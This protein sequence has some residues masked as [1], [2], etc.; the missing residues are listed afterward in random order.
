MALEEILQNTDREDNLDFEEVKI[1]TLIHL[2][3]QNTGG[4]LAK[5][6]REPYKA[7]FYKIQKEM[8][9]L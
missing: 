7:L 5:L 6:A 8:K 4:Y 1:G 9:G 3:E 2:T